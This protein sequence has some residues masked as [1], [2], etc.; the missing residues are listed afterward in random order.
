MLCGSRVRPLDFWSPSPSPLARPVTPEGPPAISRLLWTQCRNNTLLSD[1]GPQLFRKQQVKI[2][3]CASSSIFCFVLW[4]HDV[5]NLIYEILMAWRFRFQVSWLKKTGLWTSVFL[6]VYWL[7]WAGKF[8]NKSGYFCDHK[9]LPHCDSLILSGFLLKHESSGKVCTWARCFGV[10]SWLPGS[11][12][13]KIV[14]LVEKLMLP[15]NFV[16]TFPL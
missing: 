15:L 5:Q 10:C 1:F 3:D 4:R 7:P 2:P 8:N 11:P 14:T 13:T 12:K 9:E 16:I 6:V